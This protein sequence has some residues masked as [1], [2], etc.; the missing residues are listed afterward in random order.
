MNAEKQLMQNYQDEYKWRLGRVRNKYL[1]LEIMAYSGSGK[2]PVQKI[3]KTS[4]M[5]RVL[6]I[7]NRKAYLKIVRQP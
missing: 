5:L 1:I 6:V 7:R 4:I 2:K 3:L